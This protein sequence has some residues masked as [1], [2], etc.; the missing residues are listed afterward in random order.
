MAISNGKLGPG[1][2]LNQESVSGMT[3]SLPGQQWI[4]RS[5]PCRHSIM[6]WSHAGMSARFFLDMDSSGLWSDSIMKD[7]P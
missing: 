3:I 2:G 1:W 7:C 5:Y 6:H 4:V